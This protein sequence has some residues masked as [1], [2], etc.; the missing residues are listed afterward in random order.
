MH[1]KLSAD[2]KR[3]IINN[4]TQSLRMKRQ[5]L[6]DDFK[7]GKGDIVYDALISDEVRHQVE[8]LPEEFQMRGEGLY[9]TIDGNPYN[10][11]FP[12]PRIA[13]SRWTSPYNRARVPLPTPLL[14]Q[15]KEHHAELKQLQ[16]EEND[17]EAELTTVMKGCDS[18]KQLLTVWP[19][20]I[21]FL[22]PDVL[23]RHNKP[24]PKRKTADDLPKISEA[25]QLSIIK[26]RMS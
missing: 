20:A 17:L 18:L 23:A 11:E 24:N 13:P 1:V 7:T 5:K 3:A 8:R 12:S 25:T 15:F 21:D 9:L 19:T 10:F 22:P 6:A 4:L 16:K 26:V 14:T 2:T